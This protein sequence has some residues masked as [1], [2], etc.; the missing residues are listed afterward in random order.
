VIGIGGLG[1]MAL[2]FLNKWGCNVTAFTSSSAKAEEAKK[3]GAHSVI[4]THSKDELERAAGKFDFILS[5]VNVGL[6]WT[7]Y[8]SALAPK[9]RLHLVGVVPEPV[10]LP[11]FLLIAA[12]RSAGGSPSGAPATVQTMLDFC[13]RHQIRPVIEEFPMSRAN[14]AMHHLES[15]KARYR[16]ILRNDLA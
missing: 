1:H 5:T 6:D 3:L 13:A 2:Q 9:G 4:N 8:L 12:Q 14:E 7:A 15:G 16:I 10:G 11:T